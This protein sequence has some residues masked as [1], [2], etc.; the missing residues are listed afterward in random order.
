MANTNIDIVQQ[1]AGGIGTTLLAG[2]AV[3]NRRKYDFNQTIPSNLFFPRDLEKYQISMSFE[4]QQYRRR[5][6]FKQPVLKPN[7]KIRLP[8]PKTLAD[9]FRMTWGNKNQDPIVGAVIESILDITQDGRGN[10][11][12]KKLQSFFDPANIANTVGTI[13]KDTGDLGMAGLSGFA[14][15]RTNEL[16]QTMSDKI[17]GKIGL[18]EML[19]PFGLAQNPFMTVLFKNPEFK[20]HS[21]TWRLVPREPEEARIVNRII[22]EFKRALLP[23]IAKNTSGTLLNYPDTVIIGFYGGDNYLYR[24]KPCVITDMTVN[25]A[26]ATT[27]SFFKGQENVP[28]EIELS[29][30]LQEIEYWTK[31]DLDSANEKGGGYDGTGINTML[32]P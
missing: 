14:V 10:G 5:S 27:P 21:F 20:T 1:L 13:L 11:D 12:V 6:I 32:K 16:A 4:F 24:F 28:T 2:A 7:G 30:S 26:P 19:Q 3:L 23:D 8:V 31:V 22:R 17:G 25:Y 29:L 15:N 9:K 18:D